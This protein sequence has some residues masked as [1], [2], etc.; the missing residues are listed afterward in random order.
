MGMRITHDRRLA[1]VAEF[2]NPESEAK[3]DHNTDVLAFGV[4]GAK[5]YGQAYRDQ[6]D[7]LFLPYTWPGGYPVLFTVADEPAILCHYCAK[8]EY[9]K[10]NDI[11]VDVYYEGPSEYCEECGEEIESAYGDPYEDKT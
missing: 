9:L 10:G 5:G 3:N 4:A 2:L 11:N 1:Q 8:K 7:K 6:L